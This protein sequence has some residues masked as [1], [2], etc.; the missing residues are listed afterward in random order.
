MML[1]HAKLQ[2]KLRHMIDETVPEHIADGGIAI[3]P[4]HKKF[5]RY[6]FAGDAAIQPLFIN[7]ADAPRHFIRPLIPANEMHKVSLNKQHL[8]LRELGLH[9]QGPAFS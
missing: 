1:Y 5:V 8:L 4:P 3:M 9:K 7:L 2:I 6:P